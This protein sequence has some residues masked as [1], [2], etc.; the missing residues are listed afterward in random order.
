MSRRDSGEAVKSYLAAQQYQLVKKL[1]ADQTGGSPYDWGLSIA[2]TGES[3]ESSPASLAE[4]FRGFGVA[5]A[6]R[7]V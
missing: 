1:T 5:R 7:V 3:S 4:R 6:A 2:V